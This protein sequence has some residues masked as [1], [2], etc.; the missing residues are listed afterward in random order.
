MSVMPTISL[1]LSSE[2]V[3][4]LKRGYGRLWDQLRGF[5][6]DVYDPPLYEHLTLL[7]AKVNK[8]ADSNQCGLSRLTVDAVNLA[9][10]AF[11]VRCLRRET[12]GSHR[13][14]TAERRSGRVSRLLRKLEKFRRRAHRASLRLN[15]DGYRDIRRRWK[16][17]LTGV[18]TDVRRSLEY[19]FGPVGDSLQKHKHIIEMVERNARAVLASEREASPAEKDLRFAVRQCLRHIRRGRA[20]VSV[21]DLLEPTA[22][23]RCFLAGDLIRRLREL[24]RS[25]RQQ[26]LDAGIDF[27]LP[28]GLESLPETTRQALGF[29]EPHPSLAPAA[30]I[31]GK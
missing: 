11:G 17:F 25:H 26:L 14:S 18:H 3:Q 30:G 13:S 2:D 10:L 12:H 28:G 15:P 19:L 21:K 5:D 22:A 9:A 8:L 24:Q 6:F 7:K 23:G 16:A 31:S 29:A 1:R 20:P 4:I 27:D